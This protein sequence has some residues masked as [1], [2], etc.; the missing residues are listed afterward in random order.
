MSM[1]EILPVLLISGTGLLAGV[2]LAVFAK[3]FEV[4]VDPKIS[5]IGQ[6]LPGANCGACGF[7]GCDAYANAIVTENAAINLCRPGGDKARTSIANIMG[8]ADSGGSEQMYACVRCN[9]TCEA[10]EKS[11]DYQGIQTCEACN[12]FFSGNSACYYGCLGFGDCVDVCPEH[13][14][15]IIDGTATVTRSRCIGCG[16]CADKCPKQIIDMVPVSKETF[17]A[18]ANNDKGALTR[19]VCQ[20][21]CIGCKKC[22]KSCTFDAIHVINNVAQIDYSKCTGC[23]TCVEQCPIKVIL[24]YKN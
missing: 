13:A 14:I 16:L 7:A 10:T 19:K 3:V 1:T 11:M 24:T 23:N 21:G 4:K 15:S 8:V 9:G 12:S 5:Q 2:M 6:A 17:V 22:E 20:N 18:C